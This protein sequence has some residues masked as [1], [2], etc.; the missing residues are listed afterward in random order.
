M[1]PTSNKQ[2]LIIR[3][4]RGLTIAGTR[5]S[6]YDVMDL[7]K[8]QYPSKLIRDKF[9][10]TDGQINAALSYI[11]TNKTQIEAE[12]QEVLQNR[13]EIRQ[14]WEERNREHYARIAAMPHKPGQE[15][16]WAKLEEQKARRN[17]EKHEFFS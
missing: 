9:N 11:E 14:Y 1:T 4:E 13:E 15:T 3:T 2:T 12:Y 10:L 6:L 7:L 17:A 16:L 8:A 5:T